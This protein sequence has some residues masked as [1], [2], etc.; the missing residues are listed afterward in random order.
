[1][2]LQLLEK[3]AEIGESKRHGLVEEDGPRGGW[4]LL[5]EFKG[6]QKMKT[7]LLLVIVLCMYCMYST[8]Q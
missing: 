4:P 6:Q 7:I 1:M 8:V 5:Y 3:I 2:I